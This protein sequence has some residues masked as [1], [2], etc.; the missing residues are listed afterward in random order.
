V[1][2][3]VCVPDTYAC[4]PTI[5]HTQKDLHREEEQDRRGDAAREAPIYNA[6]PKPISIDASADKVGRPALS[7]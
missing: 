6:S 1:F 4:R 7:S 2:V 5:T 3:L